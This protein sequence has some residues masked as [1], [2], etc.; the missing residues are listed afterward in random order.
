MRARF[1]AVLGGGADRRRLSG[2]HTIGQRA[3]R[4]VIGCPSV[5]AV[6]CPI[7]SA[8]A[9][10]VLRVSRASR[11]PAGH[12]PGRP[13]HRQPGIDGGHPFSGLVDVDKTK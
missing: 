10:S 8:A 2:R 7:G 12:P 13:R 5:V 9:E 3:A 4:S 11:L 6:D 1:A